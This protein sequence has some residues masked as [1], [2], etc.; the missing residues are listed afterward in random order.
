MSAEKSS[1]IIRP[2]GLPT[3]GREL[4]LFNDDHNTFDHVI[5]TLIEV[6]GHEPP[7]AEQ[8]AL[9]A[10]LKGKCGVRTGAPEELKPMMLEMSSRGLTVE[11]H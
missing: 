7:Q 10:H 5:D 3:T 4:V 2:E 9:L 6:C 8:C 11:I 1:P